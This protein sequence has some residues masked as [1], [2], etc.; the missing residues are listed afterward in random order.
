MTVEA[1][2]IRDNARDETSGRWIV[3]KDGST[4][5][6]NENAS[7]P[8]LVI[9]QC[10]IDNRNLQRG[11]KGQGAVCLD[12][13]GP[14]QKIIVAGVDNPDDET[15]WEEFTIGKNLTLVK[16]PLRVNSKPVIGKFFHLKARNRGVM[17]IF[18]EVRIG[19]RD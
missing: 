2:F 17:H 9:S 16:D 10:S 13:I 3:G 1:L 12:D 14:I 18:D 8:F 11:Q 6:T 15:H 4:A 5:L 19:T 7:L